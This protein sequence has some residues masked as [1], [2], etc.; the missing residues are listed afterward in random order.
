MADDFRKITVSSLQ[1]TSSGAYSISE[2]DKDI[3]ALVNAIKSALPQDAFYHKSPKNI[4][5]S[6]FNTIG[7]LQEDFYVKNEF[8]KVAHK[9]LE[10]ALG[11]MQFKG[12]SD[13][14]YE[15]SGVRILS[16]DEEKL[17]KE[18]EE[19]NKNKGEKETETTRFNKGTMLKILG[20]VMT[21]ADI[22]R[23]ILS[24]VLSFA[25]QSVK[26]SVTAHNL[27]TSYEAIRQYRHIETT[28]GLKEGTI[29][30]ALSDIQNKFGNITALDENALEAL[31]VVMG[32]KIE[33]MATM[34]LGSSNP[35]AI[36]GAILDTFNEKAN[37][38][39]NSIGQYVGEQQARREL[40]S[41]LLRVSP[42]IA[43]VF[44][45]MQEEQHN[46]NSLFRNQAD[47]FEEWK[48]LMPT[49]RGGNLPMDYNLTVSLGKEW[50][51]V[52]DILNQIKEGI[53][54][55][56]TPAVLEL[57]QK[58]A[59]NRIGMSETQNRQRNQEN[60]EE[61]T[62]FIARASKEM[63]VM[64]SDWNNLSEVDKNY[65]YA[66]KE[67]KEKAEKANKGNSL[68]GNIAYAVPLP[69]QI[70]VRG[71]QILKE[72]MRTTEMF[73][74]SGSKSVTI[75]E[76]KDVLESYEKFNL[77]KERDKYQKQL[78]KTNEQRT[79]IIDREVK[80]RV[81]EETEQRRVD[82]LEAEKEANAD[83]VKQ[84]KDKNS[85]EFVPFTKLADYRRY[86]LL[87]ITKRLYGIDFLSKNNGNVI[88]A[89]KEAIAG[90]YISEDQFGLLNM[91]VAK[92]RD[93]NEDEI[94]KQ[95]SEENPFIGYSEEGFLTWLYE[96]NATWF[97]D[98][99]LGLRLDTLL[100]SSVD[101]KWAS[102][103]ALYDTEE[104]K[105]DWRKR[106]PNT[107][108]G[109][110]AVLGV[111]D[112]SEGEV[113]HR[114]VLDINNNGVEDKGDIILGSFMGMQGA[115]G[116]LGVLNINIEN[117][118]TDYTLAQAYGASSQGD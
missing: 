109:G 80:K 10:Q 20:A 16:R 51:V 99:I 14:K 98:K 52:Q 90:G 105:S 17:V 46:I 102:L 78:N 75:A 56:L 111:N 25:T 69:E 7:K 29:S 61:N 70:R 63:A 35:E 58:I 57:L 24:S 82:F 73:G 45:T 72:G 21:V 60:R 34:G 112:S 53:A 74:D 97:N 5:Y 66:L 86:Q 107:Y 84:S 32:G 43:D 76:I 96:K 27:G 19:L 15:A 81:S 62:A 41:Y 31:A 77:A 79:R 100:L 37:A 47:T 4:D 103:Y 95:I 3:R 91:R 83:W 106:I 18:L 39:M 12:S 8:A 22:A 40:Y 44:A 67:Y 88:K 38:G 92:Y 71:N 50:N 68:T 94:R 116:E 55:S 33:D 1:D 118:K 65:Y 54:V 36:L 108:T 110:S 48:N 93:I 85:S 49:A 114:I 9:A 101:N 30:G 42:Q 6:N 28:H 13:Y 11:K 23:R 89:V 59:D 115:T 87:G 104:T 2:Y 113:I 117:G 64:E 26:D